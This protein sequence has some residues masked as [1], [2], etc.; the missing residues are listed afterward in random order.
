MI[1]FLLASTFSLKPGVL[2]E[3]TSPVAPP[4]GA[5]DTLPEPLTLIDTAFA[6]EPL[7]G[8]CAT[9][10]SVCEPG[11]TVPPG[12]TASNPDA[13]QKPV[14]VAAATSGRFMPTVPR[15]S[16]VLPSMT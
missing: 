4:P 16:T 5:V 12:T 10:V 15:A 6:H 14:P 3:K 11:G 8:V 9:T 7:P 1:P 13:A 2:I